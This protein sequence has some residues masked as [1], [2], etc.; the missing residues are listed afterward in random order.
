MRERYISSAGN[1]RSV[2]S[3]ARHSPRTSTPSSPRAPDPKGKQ[4]APEPQAVVAIKK[5]KRT[6]KPAKPAESKEAVQE[7]PKHDPKDEP[8]PPTSGSAAQ[9]YDGT[10]SPVTE[11]AGEWATESNQKKSDDSNRKYKLPEGDEFGN[12]WGSGS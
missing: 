11:E 10:E 1:Y 6:K 7:A 2:P 8:A 9:G 3:T 4:I 5:K 12:V